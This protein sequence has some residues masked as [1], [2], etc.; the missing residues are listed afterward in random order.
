MN[1]LPLPRLTSLSAASGCGCK[2]EP[3]LLAAMLEG[4]HA[5]AAADLVVGN[6][7]ADDAAVLRL[8]GGELLVSTTDFF[9]PLVDDPYQ[10]GRI[11]AANALSDVYAMGGRPVLALA[12]MG[13]P[14]DVL[15]TAMAGQV[16]DGARALCAEAGVPLAG[17]HTIAIKEPVFGLAVQ[18]L[19]MENHLKRNTGAR[20]GD[21]L[22]LT[23]PLG[24]GMLAAALK[25]GQ[26]HP[27][28]E[29]ELLGCA[30]TLN[31]LGE[32]LGTLTGVHAL[33]DVTGF[34]LLGHLLEMCNGSG[35]AAVLQGQALP[36]LPTAQALAA[37]F[38]VPDNAFRNWN[39]YAAQ[40]TGHEPYFAALADPQTNGGLLVA[41]APH[42]VPAYEDAVRGS[43]YEAIALQPIGEVHP[44]QG[45]VVQ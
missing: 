43:A 26:L 40:A 5:P 15:G 9:T 13:W 8:P 28:G 37:Q 7:T 36:L 23:K 44:G 10:Y 39:A 38:I 27:E 34:G 3:A 12:I 20:P 35:V 6:H 18:G 42:A 33:T 45:V 4:R 1:P 2:L 31:S 17:G 30:G 14:V 21:K 25:R 29:A 41:V 22:Y 32:R 19:V 24:T 16:L 11:A